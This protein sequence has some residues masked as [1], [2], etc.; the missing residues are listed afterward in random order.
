MGRCQRTTRCQNE[1]WTAQSDKLYSD[2]A[3]DSKLR[4]VPVTD[5]ER[6]RALA[7]AKRAIARLR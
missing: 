1:M 7:V 5:A 4:R 2:S 3:V 6:T